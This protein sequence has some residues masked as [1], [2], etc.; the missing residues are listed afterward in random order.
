[1]WKREKKSEETIKILWY[2]ASPVVDLRNMTELYEKTLGL[3]K[4]KRSKHVGLEYGGTEIGQIPK[5]KDEASE[6]T[7]TAGS[8][9]DN[10]GCLARRREGTA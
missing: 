2:A 6:N 8:P 1:M 5:R 7:P 4:Y 3:A 9:V 10:V